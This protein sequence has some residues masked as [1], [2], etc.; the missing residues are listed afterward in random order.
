MNCSHYLDYRAEWDDIPEQVEIEDDDDKE[1]AIVV[2][3]YK[4]DKFL[5]SL[6]KNNYRTENDDFMLLEWFD[7]PTESKTVFLFNLEHG[8]ISVIDADTGKELHHDAFSSVFISAYQ[9]FDNREYMYISGW[10]WGPFPVRCIYHIPTFLLTPVY[11]PTN[12]S[13]YDQN[14]LRP[15]ISLYGHQTVKEFLQEADNI[16]NDM[17]IRDFTN[18]FNRNREQD[19]LLGVFLKSDEIIW[20]GNARQILTDLLSTD[21]ER[22]YIRTRGNISG[23]LLPFYDRRLYHLILYQEDDPKTID[24]PSSTYDKSKC[25]VCQERIG[26]YSVDGF[27]V[28]SYDYRRTI[29]ERSDA[30]WFKTSRTDTLS[31]LVLKVLLDG[32]ITGVPFDTFNLNFEVYSNDTKIL[33]I[34]IYQELT[35]NGNEPEPHDFGKRRCNVDPN[36]KPI[37]KI[38]EIK[39]LK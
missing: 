30:L 21:Q 34:D 37:I 28:C 15:E 27:M 35:W 16:F 20:D 8:V 26:C 7:H 9:M 39:S 3:F 5:Y 4:N 38:S 11:K 19:T 32:R 12:I 33:L 2:R 17:K 24:E 18:M 31:I 29:K 14:G 1:D 6:N 22:F 36:K 10:C 25:V 13:C 23:D